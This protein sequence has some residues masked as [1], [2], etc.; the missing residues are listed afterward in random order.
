MKI[1]FTLISFILSF[2]QAITQQSTP[3]IL[4]IIADDLGIDAI[5]G[6]GLDTETP[7][8]PN[9]DMLRANG[10]SFVNT[11]ATPQCTPT[12]AAIMSGKHG[13]KTGVMRPPGNLDLVHESIFDHINEN[14]ESDYA[15]AVI[16]KWHISNPVDYNHPMQHGID[17]YEGVFTA[18]VE[19]YYNWEKIEN[20]EVTQVEEYVT[21][22]FTNAAI[23]WIGEQDQPWFLWLSREVL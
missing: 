2:S 16:G 4:L 10:L 7:N 20:G 15:T 5:E 13:I 11:W 18:A 12:R 14:S 9:L 23:D 3:N 21:T 1:F 6:F 22:N 19:D 8:T 17:H